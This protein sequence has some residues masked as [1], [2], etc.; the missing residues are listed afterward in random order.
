MKFNSL[1]YEVD[2]FVKDTVLKQKRERWHEDMT[3][4]VYIE[5]SLNVLNDLATMQTKT[6]VADF[7]KKQKKRVD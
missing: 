1:P 5:E 6:K 2:L 3:K 7:N 4:D